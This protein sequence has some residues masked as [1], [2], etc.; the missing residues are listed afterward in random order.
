MRGSIMA[1]G[2]LLLIPTGFGPWVVWANVGGT[3]AGAVSLAGEFLG[4]RRDRARAGAA[5]PAPAST[6]S[7]AAAE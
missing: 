5:P 3:L 7:S 2:I 6:A 1:A 4:A